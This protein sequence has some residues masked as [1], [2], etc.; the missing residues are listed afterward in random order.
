MTI[1]SYL[2]LENVTIE[3]ADLDIFKYSDKKPGAGYSMRHSGIHT[4]QFQL[5]NFK[6]TLKLQ[7]TL[8]LYPG[9]NDWID[10]DYDSGLPLYSLDSTAKTVDEARNFTGNWLWIRAAYVLEQGTIVSIRYN[11]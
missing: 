7:G 10:L 2:I 4:V 6:G 5:D 3:S 9:E 1:E 8:E 11:F